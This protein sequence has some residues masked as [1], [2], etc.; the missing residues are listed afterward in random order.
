MVAGP[1]VCGE[2]RRAP[3]MCFFASWLTIGLRCRTRVAPGWRSAAAA[4][5]GVQKDRRRG[6]GADAPG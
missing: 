2:P 3:S 1:R 6:H 4:G 5:A